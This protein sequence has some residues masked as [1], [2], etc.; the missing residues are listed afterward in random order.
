MKMVRFFLW[1][2][3]FVIFCVSAVQADICVYYSIN[4]DVNR[5]PI[6]SYIYGTNFDWVENATM[7]KT[8]GNRITGYNWENN[9]S[10]AGKDWYHSNDREMVKHLPW[11]PQQLVPGRHLTDFQDAAL[12]AGASTFITL[13]M[14]GYVSAD[15]YGEVYDYETA[16]SY[17]WKQVVYDKGAPF[18]VPPGN[19]DTTDGYVYI[20]ECVN[21]LVSKYGHA[22]DPCGVKGYVLDNEPDIWSDG[23]GGGTHPR[24]H[25]AQTTCAELI[26]KSVALSTAVKNVDPDALILGYASYGF[27]GYYA[28]QGAPDWWG[29][30]WQYNW[31]IDYYLE[32]MH[33]A[34]INAGR[35]LLDVLD[36]HWYPE[37]RGDGKR[38]A[39]E[40]WPPYNRANAAARMQAPRTLWDPDYVVPDYPPYTIEESW[41]ASSSWF[42]QYLP[43]LPMVLNSINTY[44]PGTK[45]AISE[46]CYGAEDHISGGIATADV[47]GIFGKYGVY[48]GAYWRSTWEGGDTSYVQA[49]FKLYR[50]YDGAHST[51]GDTSVDS[52]TSDK[53][54]SPIYASVFD[55]NDSQLHLIV[56][57]KNFDCTINGTF[58]IDSRQNFI[59]GRVWRFNKWT[60]DVTEVSPSINNITDNVFHYSIPP[61][62]VC[63]IALQA[64][65]PDWDMN[66]DGSVNIKDLDIFAHRWLDPYNFAD[67]SQLAREWNQ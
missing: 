49:A 67:F 52:T 37:A 14:A 53:V 54:N 12:A 61:L 48:M 34:E 1:L 63:H 43:I 8:G 9:F 32:R 42:R 23:Y 19:P 65:S 41:I 59:S 55:G 33:Q 50:N 31:F 11:G 4:T 60:S 46:Y 15:D 25:P 38:I 44:Y 39:F 40:S 66:K 26:D 6:S 17:R 35:R 7:R 21:F 28:L 36:L 3:A 29:I 45:L 22:G 64:A 58:D 5:N 24:L 57:N 62:T 2:A 16:P 18:C 30:S 56:I 20:D 10:N 13:Q 51:F 47:L 27:Y